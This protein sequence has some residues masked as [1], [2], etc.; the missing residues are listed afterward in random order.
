MGRRRS[1]LNSEAI[2]LKSHFNT[3]RNKGRLAKYFKE[4][5]KT[6]VDLAAGDTSRI[7][8]SDPARLIQA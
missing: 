5:I 6:S 1:N 2:E 8:L 3:G 4:F 7:N